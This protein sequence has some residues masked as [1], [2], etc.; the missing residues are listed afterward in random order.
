MAARQAN[1]LSHQVSGCP[2]HSAPSKCLPGPRPPSDVSSTPY[3]QAMEHGAT[4]A[5]PGICTLCGNERQQK[6]ALG[7]VHAHGFVGNEA[8]FVW[9]LGSGTGGVVH[10]LELVTHPSTH[11]SIHPLTHSSSK[12]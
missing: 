2:G 3:L 4:F 11:L 6:L 7:V 8:G 10:C 5:S 9:R 12:P 1:A